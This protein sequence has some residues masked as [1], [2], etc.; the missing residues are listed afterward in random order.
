MLRSASIRR[1][2]SVVTV[3]LLSLACAADDPEPGLS[4]AQCEAISASL[5]EAAC[6]CGCHVARSPASGGMLVTTF[7]SV[8]LC[9]ET[10]A[11]DCDGSGGTPSDGQVCTA[12]VEQKVSQTSCEEVLAVPDSCT[13]FF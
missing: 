8:T 9:S 10:L 3:L 6:D 1:S 11:S 12:D 4:E 5:C 7:S 2:V 13:P